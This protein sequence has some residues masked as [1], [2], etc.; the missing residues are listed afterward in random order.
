[1]NF[2]SECDFWTNTVQSR[3]APS[4]IHTIPRSRPTW[5]D[6]MGSYSHPPELQK[7]FH[8]SLDIKIHT[9]K[10]QK[11]SKMWHSTGWWLHVF[12]GPF[13]FLQPKSK[14]KTYA[15]LTRICSVCSMINISTF[16]AQLECFTS[17][18]WLPTPRKDVTWLENMRWKPAI[19]QFLLDKMRWCT[20]SS[21][22]FLCFKKSQ[23]DV[24]SCHDFI[25]N[26]VCFRGAL[27]FILR[28]KKEKNKC[29]ASWCSNS[30]KTLLDVFSTKKLTKTLSLSG[31]Q[32]EKKKKASRKC[33]TAGGLSIRKP[34]K[35]PENNKNLPA[36]L[37]LFCPRKVKLSKKQRTRK[38]K[39]N[40]IGTLLNIGLVYRCIYI[41]ALYRHHVY[42]IDKS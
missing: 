11:G 20:Q 16:L 22:M 31:E 35:P 26:F 17:K 24:C 18:F 12:F 13:F 1:M 41:H 23:L 27:C 25:C 33:A 8:E 7:R 40:D 37:R 9:S 10:H 42:N 14:R 28:S 3:R 2:P 15:Q 29:C 5:K 38:A 4:Q 34:P 30:S 6:G 39:V 32:F 21:Q 36:N 19:G